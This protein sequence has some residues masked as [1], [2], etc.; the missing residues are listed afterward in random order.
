[1]RKQYFEL[2]VLELVYGYMDNHTYHFYNKAALENELKDIITNY[3]ENYNEPISISVFYFDEV[4]IFGQLV[5]QD[6]KKVFEWHK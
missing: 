4:E 5:K 1:M 6:V 3:E 2:N